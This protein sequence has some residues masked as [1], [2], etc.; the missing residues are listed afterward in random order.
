MRRR[1]SRFLGRLLLRGVVLRC[2]PA[3]LPERLAVR[4]GCK[5]PA[6]WRWVFG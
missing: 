5:S 6:R 4:A 3:N 2:L 1:W